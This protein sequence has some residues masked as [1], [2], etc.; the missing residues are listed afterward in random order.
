MSSATVGKAKYSYAFSEV[1]Y[2][3]AV[4]TLKTCGIQ[5]GILQDAGTFLFKTHKT[6]TV[7][8]KL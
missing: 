1:P 4:K 2:F 7:P 6:R 3:N 8:E 5:N